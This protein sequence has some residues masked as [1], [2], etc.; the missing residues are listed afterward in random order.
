MTTMM[1]ASRF[2]RFSKASET[3]QLEMSKSIT[4]KRVAGSVRRIV[5]WTRLV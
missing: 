2:N 1:Q 3:R 5:P 4:T